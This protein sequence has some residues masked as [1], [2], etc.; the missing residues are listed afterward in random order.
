MEGREY[1]ELR[2]S[3]SL[4]DAS[5]VGVITSEQESGSG[6]PLATVDEPSNLKSKLQ[7]HM[8]RRNGSR[9]SSTRQLNE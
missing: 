2:Q 8:Y 1:R 5:P 7:S 3:N 6:A 9:K 4:A